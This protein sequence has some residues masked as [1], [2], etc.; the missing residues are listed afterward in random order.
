MR[1]L[2]SQN[3]WT[4][5]EKYGAIHFEETQDVAW[6]QPKLLPDFLGYRYLATLGHFGLTPEY[7]FHFL[8]Q[9]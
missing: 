3:E 9:H 4:Q 7:R 8:F 1:A 5:L 6:L 2:L